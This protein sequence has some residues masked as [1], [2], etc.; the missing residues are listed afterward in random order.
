MTWEWVLIPFIPIML[1]ILGLACLGVFLLAQIKTK[2]RFWRYFADDDAA[3]FGFLWGVG[4][5]LFGGLLLAVGES[6]AGVV[7][8]LLSA[9]PFAI[10]VL[11][12]VGI[13]W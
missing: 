8:L 4:V 10:G 1:P 9:I 12:S 2:S 5:A 3:F 13:D 7:V 11:A 6:T